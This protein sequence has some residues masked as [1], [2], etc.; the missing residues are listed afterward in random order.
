[1]TALFL[2]HSSKDDPLATAFGAWLRQNE[3]EAFIDHE[4]ISGGA[5]WADALRESAGACRV[6][7]CLI[8]DHWLASA[9]C[10]NEF[11]SA[12]YMGKRILP[13]FARTGAPVSDEAGD[14][15]RRVCA[16]DQG[17]DLSPLFDGAGGLDFSKNE[18]HTAAL[19][20]ALR[21]AGAMARVGLD[22][23]AFDIDKTVRP[24]PFPGLASFGDEDADAAIFFGRSRELAGTLEI[25]RENRAKPSPEPLVILGAS[26]SGKSSLLKA[27]IIPRLRREAPAWI[28]LRAFRPGADP[29][30]NFAEAI[31]KTLAD[32]GQ[33]EAHGALKRDLFETWSKAPRTADGLTAEGRAMVQARLDAEGH[34]LRQA[35]ARPAATLLISVDQ[36]EEIARSEGD[37]GDALA[38]YLRAATRSEVDASGTRAASE[39]S[40]AGRSRFIR[41]RDPVDWHLVFTTRTD[42][43]A[44]LQSHP[45]FQSL[46]VRG[47][48]LRALPVFHF[49]DVVDEPAKRYGVEVAPE[50]IDALVEDAPQRDALPLLAFALDR[51]WA[52]FA[53]AGKLT[54]RDYRSMGGIQGLIEDAAE[55]ALLGLTA[56]VPRPAGIGR[57]GA[58]NLG[59]RTFVPALVDVNEQGEYIRRVASWSTF[60]E[61]SQA[62][63]DRFAEWRLVVKKADTQTV[64]VAHEALFR[65]WGR[66]QGWLEPERARLEALR[67]L[68]AAAAAWDRRGRSPDDLT[69][70]G[71]RLR[72]ATKLRTLARF[73]EHLTAT[74][75]AYLDACQAQERRQKNRVR[76]AV[77]SAVAA[78]A[79]FAVMWT[80]RDEVTAQW[81]WWTVIRPFIAVEVTP[82]VLPADKERGLKHG[83]TFRECREHCPEM[84]VVRGGSFE[85]GDEAGKY[86]QML[87]RRTYKQMLPRHPVTIA[88]PFAVG[89]TEVTFDEWALCVEYGN[90]N[91]VSDSG[92]GKGR[93]PVINVT[94]ADAQTYVRWL[95]GV[96]GQR[97]RLLTDAEWEYVARAGTDT[98]YSWGGEIGTNRANCK[99]CGSEWDGK[100]TAPV[101]SFEANAFGLYDVH[102]NVWEWVEDC[103]HETYDGAPADG[104]AWL[105]SDQADCSKA[106]IRGGSWLNAP[107]RVRSAIRF[108]VAR[109][110]QNYDL[111]FRIARTLSDR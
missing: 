94:W 7:S 68:L 55:R 39:A 66:L 48:D 45:R 76:T 12:W 96:T 38:D 65:K 27:G 80:Y 25:L 21:A 54:E 93:R 16:E 28:P 110:D 8:T 46:E 84:V 62:L 17:I 75:T 58:D 105:N 53:A 71:P 42:S 82:F 106:V 63:L 41:D 33:T 6:V 5:K 20:Q 98:A 79:L 61:E 13:L 24:T 14:R 92:F 73:G 69:H 97:Y 31:T 9:E 57:K 18:A 102:G 67:G 2:S 70:F 32:F 89:R 101:A 37:S 77:A 103:W 85:M 52:Q 86:K 104:T 81:R 35:A 23:Y 59:A 87:P 60:D 19:K 47:Y 50:L 109:G 100:S 64:E 3:V 99:G 107:Y 111:G 22:P 29:L 78:L 4:N 10:F 49:D 56:D 91:E 83:D 26:G 72:E 36:G 44:E 95:S 1:M 34:R 108:R 43:F 88:Q 40:E 51:L 74:E 11:L 30:L 90:C 15:L